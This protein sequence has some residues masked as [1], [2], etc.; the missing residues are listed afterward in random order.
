MELILL[1]L[2]GAHVV[3]G[4]SLCIAV[5]GARGRGLSRRGRRLIS[6]CCTLD[7]ALVALVGCAVSPFD[8]APGDFVGGGWI[9]TGMA[10]FLFIASYWI[11][12]RS[13]MDWLSEPPCRLKAP[14]A[15]RSTSHGRP[16]P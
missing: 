14:D 2:L 8:P 10:L 4:G 7:A 9:T 15:A 16:R 1:A 11:V 5:A 12:A 3:L 13:W 6:L